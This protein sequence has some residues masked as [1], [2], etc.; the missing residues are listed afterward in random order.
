MRS[1]IITE[2]AKNIHFVWSNGAGKTTASLEILPEL[3]HCDEFINADEIARGLSPF[4]P[5]SVA[6]EAGRIQLDRIKRL[7]GKRQDFS[8]ETTLSTKSYRNLIREAHDIGYTIDL[9]FFWLP[10]PEIAME[11]VKMRVMAGGHNIP[12][13]VIRRR[14]KNGLRNLFNIYI[15]IV[16]RWTLLSNANVDSYIIASYRDGRLN[17]IDEQLYANIKEYAEQR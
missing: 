10:S 16:N 1:D 2:Y 15:P 13:D 12:E 4:N 11:R 17:I 8:I 5:E 9:L 3:L 14:Y 7:M 6:I